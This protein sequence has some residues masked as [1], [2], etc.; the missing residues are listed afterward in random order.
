MAS[1]TIARLLVD[2]VEDPLQFDIG[3]IDLVAI[4]SCERAAGWRRASLK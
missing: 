3:L 4:G 1:L 2:A